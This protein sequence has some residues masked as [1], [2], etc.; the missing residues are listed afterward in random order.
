MSIIKEK[1]IGNSNLLYLG[2][3]DSYELYCALMGDDDKLTEEEY[4]FIKIWSKKK[5]RTRG[6]KNE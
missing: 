3:A 4:T 5:P 1:C 2:K 6:V